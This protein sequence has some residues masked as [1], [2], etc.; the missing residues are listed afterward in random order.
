MNSFIPVDVRWF[1]TSDNFKSQ[2]QDLRKPCII[3]GVD[4]GSCKMKW[5][6]EYL[7]HKAQSKMATVH[8]SKTPQMDFVC[9]NYV[10]RKLPFNELIRRASEATH[11]NYFLTPDEY[12]YFRSLG[13]DVRKEP[14]DIS[15]QWPEIFDDVNLPDF[16]PKDR[17]FSS[18]FRISSAGMQLWTHYDVMDNLLMQVNGCKKVILFPPSDASNL[19]LEGDKSS[20]VDIEEPNLEKFPKFSNITKY[21]CILQ[22]GDILFIPA[23]WFHN[24]TALDFGIAINVFWKN[25]DIK[26]YDT[27]DP[28]GNKDLIPAARSMDIMHRALKIL[29][30]L[31]EDYRDFYARKMV[32][33]VE[34]LT[35]INNI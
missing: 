15:R 33:K 29:N 7:S 30:E 5:T 6:A 1:I 18:V 28:Y 23:L 4:I 25:L 24:V 22:P 19:Y 31:P 11:E 32:A 21:K 8:V 12:Y 35:Y 26:L 3:K 34:K 2:V 27:K 16:F 14:S 20:V 13:E 17:F 9:K 10:Y